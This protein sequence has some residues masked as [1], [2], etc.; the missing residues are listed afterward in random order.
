MQSV[1]EKVEIPPESTVRAFTRREAQF[2]FAWHHHPGCEL[3]LIVRGQG[4]R[5]VG[6]HVESYEPGEFVL[7]GPNLS[8]TWQSHSS[9]S[10]SAHEAIVVQFPHDRI[11]N[12]WSQFPEFRTIEQ[13]MQRA[14]RGVC[15]DPQETTE[16][17][18]CFKSL[19]AAR[20]TLRLLGLLELLDR[21]AAKPSRQLASEAFAMPMDD[22]LRVRVQPVLDTI[23]QNYDQP[24]NQKVLAQKIGLSAS[25]FSRLFAKATGVKFSDYVNDLRIGHACRMLIESDLPITAISHQAG[26]KNLSNFNRTFLRLRHIPPRD[27][28]SQYRGQ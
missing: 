10:R 24:L 15:F 21:F 1:F 3:T 7:I 9:H 16:E 4:R 18:K 23:E 13:L 2:P 25:A 22:T 26:F 8:H 27:F 28:R 19:V 6:D 5:F 14:G 20:P 11:S 12:A 17:V